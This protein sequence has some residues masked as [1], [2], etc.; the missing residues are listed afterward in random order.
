MFN[1]FI[2][3]AKCSICGVT[4]ENDIVLTYDPSDRN[5]NKNYGKAK[6][7]CIKHFSETWIDDLKDFSGYSFCFLP[8]QNWNSYS[9]ITLDRAGSWNISRSEI[10][11]IDGAIN[12]RLVNKNC[13]YCSGSA[14]FLLCESEYT[15]NIDRCDLKELCYKHFAQ[16]VIEEI[17]KNKLMLDE[18]TLPYG[19]RGLFMQGEL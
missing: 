5:S 13:L 7:L 10:E 11:N 1:L 4:R 8:A 9:Y 17:V 6:N 19:N 3:K 12:E 15:E 18:V 16:L 2:R 14:H